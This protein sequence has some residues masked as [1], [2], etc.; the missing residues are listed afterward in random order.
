MSQPLTVVLEARPLQLAMAERRAFR[1][2]IKVTNTT[3]ATLDPDLDRSELLV[4]GE[5]TIAWPNTIMNSGRSTEWT[6][7]PS[8][9]SVGGTWSIGERLFSAPGEYN[10][11]LRVSGV[12][13]PAV[14][15][16]VSGP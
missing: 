15:V 9:H 3:T 6:A 16:V 5:P 1:L 4:N 10:L 13:S 11:T 7:L 14:Q 8:G 12:V 2:T